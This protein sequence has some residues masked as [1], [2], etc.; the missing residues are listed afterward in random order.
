M[1]ISWCPYLLF[2][3]CLYL[4]V[5]PHCLLMA[6]SQWNQEKAKRSIIILCKL[7]SG[8]APAKFNQL[9]PSVN[10]PQNH[11]HASWMIA[12]TPFVITYSF[13]TKWLVQHW[14]VYFFDLVIIVIQ[15]PP[16]LWERIMLRLHTLVK[17]HYTAQHD[18]LLR[19]WKKMRKE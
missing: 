6:W 15:K 9:F 17:W 16:Q 19:Q 3:V 13:K 2:A 18:S 4:H 11:M 1:I 8:K 10:I 14:L 5:G 7:L 12:N